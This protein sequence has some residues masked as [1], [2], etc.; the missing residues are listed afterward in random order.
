MPHTNPGCLKIHY[1]R[2]HTRAPAGS[3]EARMR[4]EADVGKTKEKAKKAVVVEAAPV[5]ETPVVPAKVKK[6]KKEKAAVVEAAPAPAPAKPEKK[7]KKDK[8]KK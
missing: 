1:S 2:V 3:R 4:K 7:S 8:K 5:V 6:A